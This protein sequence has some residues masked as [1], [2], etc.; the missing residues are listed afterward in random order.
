MQKS[1]TTFFLLS[2]RA[3]ELDY[4]QTEQSIPRRRKLPFAQKSSHIFCVYDSWSHGDEIS[5]GKLLNLVKDTW[6]NENIL[7]RYYMGNIM[8]IE[9]Q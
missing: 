1:K 9:T 7:W 2:S 4:P 8:N 6:G 5:I 3:I